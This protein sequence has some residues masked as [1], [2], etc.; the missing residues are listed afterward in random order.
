L[1]SLASQIHDQL[2]P[3][4]NQNQK[5][6]IR[7]PQSSKDVY[8]LSGEESLNSRQPSSHFEMVLIQLTRSPRPVLS[9]ILDLLRVYQGDIMKELLL[10]LG[11][12]MVFTMNAFSSELTSN[13]EPS[14]SVEASK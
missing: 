1:R 14:T 3:V 13:A 5:S 7:A 10:I 12:A 9:M 6:E 2:E 11:L 8:F 4:R